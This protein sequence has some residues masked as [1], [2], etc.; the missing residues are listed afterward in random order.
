MAWDG[1]LSGLAGATP[2]IY[3][4]LLSSAPPFV[5]LCKVNRLTD[6]VLVSWTIW[7]CASL[8]NVRN[9]GPVSLFWPSGDPIYQMPD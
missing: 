7:H 1:P 9:N 6:K 8:F 4:W 2:V 5:P 3:S